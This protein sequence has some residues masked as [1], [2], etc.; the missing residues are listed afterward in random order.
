MT[1]QLHELFDLPPEDSVVPN[2]Q[3]IEQQYITTETLTNI[4]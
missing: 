1:K 3:P 4:E 2:E